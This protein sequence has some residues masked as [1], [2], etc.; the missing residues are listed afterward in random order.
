MTRLPLLKVMSLM[1]ISA[2]AIFAGGLGVPSLCEQRLATITPDGTLVTFFPN[3]KIVKELVTEYEEMQETTTKLVNGKEVPEVV[4]RQVPVTKE[5][6]KC[7]VE[8]ADDRTNWSPAPGKSL[9]FETNGKPIDGDSLRERLKQTTLVVVSVS[10]SMI[11]ENVAAILKPGTIVLV[12]PMAAHGHGPLPA[13][14]AAVDARPTVSDSSFRLVTLQDPPAPASEKPRIEL[15][16]VTSQPPSVVAVAWRNPDQV[17]LTGR[18]EKEFLTKGVY[19]VLEGT[20]KV[21][22]VAEVRSRFVNIQN[23]DYPL[24]SVSAITVDGRRLTPEILQR[25]LQVERT[26]VVPSTRDGVDPF[27]LQNFRP[28]VVVMTVPDQPDI[29]VAPAPMPAP[30]PAPHDPARAPRVSPSEEPSV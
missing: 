18:F 28:V 30:R 17:T 21:L 15:P 4:T 27:W 10:G 22:K 26:V 8:W 3:C 12:P 23:V 2:P 1:L 16:T 24:F 5:V 19:E 7:V 9:A 25:Y 6:R 11:P 20:K 29:V 14:P 13:P